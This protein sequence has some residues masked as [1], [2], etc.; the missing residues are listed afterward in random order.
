VAQ[1]PLD[2]RR[3][4]AGSNGPGGGQRM[5]YSIDGGASWSQVA[6]PLGGTGC[7]PTVAWSS[8]GAH[9]SAAT[10]GGADGVWVYR[11]ADGGQSWNDLETLTPGDPRREFGSGT[12]KEYL[13][14]DTIAGSPCLDHVYALWQEFG[15]NRFARST[16]RAHTWS[17][18]LSVSGA[19]E[20]GFGA[21]L[22]SDAAGHVFY[23]WP[24]FDRRILVARSTTCGASF[25]PAL[26]V[27]PTQ[28]SYEWPLPSIETRQAWNYVSADA[29]RSAGAYAGSLYVAFADTTAPDTPD[30]SLNHSVVRVAR[31]RDG[32]AS[33]AVAAPHPT[34]DSETVDRWNPWLRVGPDGVVHVVF[35]DTRHSLAR[36]GVDLFH[37]R[38]LDG[39]VSW[40][41]PERL[42][43]VTS[44]NILDGFEFGDYNGLD[45]SAGNL[46]GIFTDNR[47]E[48]VGS[49]DSVDVYVAGTTTRVFLDDFELGSTL[50]WSSVAP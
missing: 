32:G 33:W 44:S 38:S 46:L 35:Y 19:G 48:T 8:A 14:V 18:P 37:A 42:T 26:V 9:A 16:D 22:T 29:D 40:S 24:A 27:T 12:D 2:D 11:S 39:G 6:R 13:H 1:H 4:V 50:R 47:R 21:D 17:A 20:D 7:D 41:P 25:E 28:A 34:D 49:G 5:H 10:L 30:P 31:S 3:V 23:F 45:V 43:S 15:D 36:T